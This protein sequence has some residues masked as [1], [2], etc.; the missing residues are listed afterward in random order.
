[1]IFICANIQFNRT[2]C[3]NS[4]SQPHGYSVA[5]LIKRT[6]QRGVISAGLNRQSSS[7]GMS[8]SPREARSNRQI[9]DD[10][11][12]L[13][14]PTL[15]RPSHTDDGEIRV[16][17]TSAPRRRLSGRVPY[18][19]PNDS[20]RR[21]RSVSRSTTREGQSS[22]ALDQL[23]TRSRARS[24]SRGELPSNRLKSE[25]DNRHRSSSRSRTLSDNYHGSSKSIAYGRK[26]STSSMIEADRRH[27]S[28]SRSQ[29]PDENYYGTGKSVD[30]RS[31][32]LSR[33]HSVEVVSS[34]SVCNPTSNRHGSAYDISSEGKN[35]YRRRL[36]VDEKSR[37]SDSTTKRVNSSHARSLS[38]ESYA[39]GEEKLKSQQKSL[40][41]QQL[42]SPGQSKSKSMYDASISDLKS[43]ISRG[44][45]KSIARCERGDS[46]ILS[47][48]RSFARSLTR[49]RSLSR[50]ASKVLQTTSEMDGNKD[51]EPC[52][53][54]YEVPFNPS[55]GKC[56][57]HP[58]VTL[59]VKN[60]G[61]RG[62]WKIVTDSCPRCI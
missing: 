22:P 30:P 31:F 42:F 59:A 53:Q 1:M 49:R 27:R 61:L 21:E 11:V 8:K 18:G 16:H 62:G 6:S 57:Y 3:R 52:T 44:R 35:I 34:R 23:D 9:T 41:T 10:A 55:T 15:R 25:T 46:S 54:R 24:V 29:V 7:T 56:N 48:G 50:G 14:L 2:F 4:Q 60:G 26:S 13:P 58:E 51:I 28:S 36:S 32:A 20:S 12:K 40:H 37:H 43:F 39:H 33:R 5:P 19:E 38:K 47:A 45:S 17:E